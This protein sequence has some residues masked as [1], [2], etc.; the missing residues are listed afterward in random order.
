MD[1]AEDGVEWSVV[2]DGHEWRAGWY[3][4][5]DPPPGTWHG[6]AGVCLV[7]D[8][9]VLVTGDGSRWGLPGGRPEPGEDW[10]ATLRREVEEEACATVVDAR[11]LGYSRGACLQGPEAG[12]VL[13]RSHW[14]AQVRLDPWEPRFEM[15]ARQLV[16][17]NEVLARMWIADGFAPLYHRMFAEAALATG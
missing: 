11:L 4:P 13:V 14:L 8:H 12:V 15:T 1:I 6:S 3:P 5:P 9:I 10:Y 16:P 2:S 17:A 7:Q